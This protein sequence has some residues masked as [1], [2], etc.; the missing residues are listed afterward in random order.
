[1]PSVSPRRTVKDTSSNSPGRDRPL[2]SSMTGLVRRIAVR[3]DWSKVLPVIS[4]VRR[5]WVMPSVG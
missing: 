5:D 2:T 1:M 3:T 4:S